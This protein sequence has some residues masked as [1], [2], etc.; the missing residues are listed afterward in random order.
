MTPDLRHFAQYPSFIDGELDKLR[1]KRVLMYCT[2]GVRCEQASSYLLS[3]HVA[4][5]VVQLKGGIC[6]YLERFQEEPGFFRGKNFVFDYRRYEPW[7]DDTV[8]GRCDGCGQPWDN[9][10]NGPEA[11]CETC[12]TLLLLCDE[13]RSTRNPSTQPE[14]VGAVPIGSSLPLLCGGNTCTGEK[15]RC[16]CGCGPECT[17]GPICRR[18]GHFTRCEPAVASH[19]Q[20]QRERCS[21]ARERKEAVGPVVMDGHSPSRRGC[22]DG[23]LGGC[24]AA[25]KVSVL[26]HSPSVG[27][28][29]DLRVQVASMADAE[30]CLRVI[31]EAYIAQYGSPR[32]KDVSNV[33][34][35]ISLGCLLVVC[36]AHGAVLGCAEHDPFGTVAE[37]VSYGPVAVAPQYQGS[38]IGSAL[39]DEIERRARRSNCCALQLEVRRHSRG[40]DLARFYAQRGYETIGPRHRNYVV[41]RKVLRSQP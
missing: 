18:T 26:Q 20:R 37:V 17:T 10:D 13:C 29:A 7:H 21:A 3:K 23:L 31:N 24:L 4:K 15:I 14:S 1:G 5:E 12:R 35:S 34:S 27:D 30:S 41:L 2:G 40:R 39:V 6:R 16:G 8:V 25:L 9:Y 11:R 22:W 33:S 28:Y 38:S 36:D 32:Y 19:G